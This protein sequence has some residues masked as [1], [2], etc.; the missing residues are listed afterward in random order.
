[1]VRSARP[2]TSG[3]WRAAARS[4]S[5]CR[6]RPHGRPASQL[7]I[8][9]G[10]VDQQPLADARRFA[11]GLSSWLVRRTDGTNEWMVF[12]RPA[13]SERDLVVLAE[14]AR[15]HDHSAAS[16]RDRCGLSA[17]FGVLRWQGFTWHHEPPVT[18]WIDTVT[19]SPEH[20]D[21]EV[22]EAMLEFAVHDLGS[23]GI[24]ALLIYRP[25]AEP[26]PP[27]RNGCRRR[28]P[29]GSAG[30]APRP[31]APRTRP[32]RRR[33][34]LRRRRGAASARR[35]AGA[36]QRGRRDRR[37][38]RRHPPHVGSPLQL[39]RS[40][41]HR[42]RGE[43]GRSRFGAPQRRSARPLAQRLK[44]QPA[45]RTQRASTNVAVVQPRLLTQVEGRPRVR[46]LR[47]RA[48]GAGL[49]CGPA[50]RVRPCAPSASTSTRRAR[51]RTRG[52]P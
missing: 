23:R 34:H 16:R 36:E 47:V 19:A 46:P 50:R 45:A 29:C 10:P 25:D 26:G 3:G 38:V 7:E 24:G 17:A 13:G 51:C 48:S 12:D 52:C 40:T 35:A 27:S 4:S 28:R 41:R 9:R 11:D 39:R 5:R 33:R 42:D 15:R 43:R 49:P 32:D 18:S 1:M 30:L 20:G 44:R 2:C 8:T 22:L 37:S 21:P 6:I 14:R 31:A